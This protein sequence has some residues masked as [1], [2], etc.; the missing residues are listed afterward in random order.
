MTLNKNMNLFYYPLNL[1]QL[2]NLFLDLKHFT[3]NRIYYHIGYSDENQ[4]IYL[5]ID[6]N[7]WNEYY[8][9]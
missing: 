8:H 5:T 7:N 1:L 2:V 9:D 3:R 6:L 4:N